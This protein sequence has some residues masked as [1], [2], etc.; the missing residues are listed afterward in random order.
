MLK[1][2]CFVVRVRALF[3]NQP[4]VLS[5]CLPF[6]SE[7]QLMCIV[8]PTKRAGKIT[9]FECCVYST[10]QDWKY[11]FILNIFWCDRFGF[12]FTLLLPPALP[13]WH[14]LEPPAD[15]QQQ[16]ARAGTSPANGAAFP[17]ERFAQGFAGCRWRWILQRLVVL[18]WV[19]SA[20]TMGTEACDNITAQSKCTCAIRKY[21]LGY[22]LK[23]TPGVKEEKS[24]VMSHTVRSAEKM[25]VVLQVAASGVWLAPGIHIF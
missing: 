21:N 13:N 22:N 2:T 12:I 17:G 3:S 20:G 15:F 9:S 6:V 10:E 5:D 19:T 16:A 11:C 4:S 1:M 23:V 25:T 7:V 14:F 24:D 8:L 18:R